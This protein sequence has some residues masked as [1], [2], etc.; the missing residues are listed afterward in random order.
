MNLLWKPWVLVMGTI[1]AFL[2]HL[3]WLEDRKTD[4]K[5]DWEYVKRMR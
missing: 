4:R 5:L 2:Y 1:L 3:V